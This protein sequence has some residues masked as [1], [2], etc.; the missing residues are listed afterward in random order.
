MN[1]D[2]QVYEKIMSLKFKSFTDEE[3]QEFKEKSK[4]YHK[5]IPNTNGLIP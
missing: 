3:Y 5:P 4:S 2:T 1:I